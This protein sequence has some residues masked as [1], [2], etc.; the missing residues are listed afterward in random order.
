M[1]GRSF[2]K[3]RNQGERG[4]RDREEEEEKWRWREK[5]LGLTVES[6]FNSGSN[7]GHIMVY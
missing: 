3:A 6:F 7:E 2:S 4:G 1:V 5:W